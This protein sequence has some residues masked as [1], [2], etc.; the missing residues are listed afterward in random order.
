[1]DGATQTRNHMHSLETYLHELVEI[2]RS[3]VGVKETS[4]YPVLAALLNDIGKTLKPKVKCIIHPKSKG[5]GIPDG[6]LFTADQL[7]GLDDGIDPLE[8]QLPARAV[9]EVKGTNADVDKLVE[10]SQVAKYLSKYGLVLATNYYAF[11]LVKAG[12]QTKFNQIWTGG[13][14]CVRPE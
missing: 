5:A 7:K 8:G 12:I 14:R 13:S 1:M 6:G 11:L 3:G 9:L 10:S 4:Y 2:H